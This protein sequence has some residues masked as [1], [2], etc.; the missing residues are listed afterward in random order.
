[1]EEIL[2]GLLEG[3]AQGQRAAPQR[4]AP[5]ADPLTDILGGIL[6][7]SA[8]PQPRRSGGGDPMAE[9]LEGILGG[10]GAPASGGDIDPIMGIL[11]GILGGGAPQARPQQAGA[12][13]LAD[14]LGGILGGGSNRAAN[15]I[16]NM[17]AEKL[18]ISPMI[19]NMIVSFFMAKLLSNKVGHMAPG[20]P[21][22]GMNVRPIRAERQGLD[23]DDLLDVMESGND[24]NA[25]LDETGMTRDLAKY[26]GI[27]KGTASNGLQELLKIFGSKR[28]GPAPVRSG[29]GGLEG[30]LDTWETG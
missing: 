14:I 18:G 20:A 13:G 27:D 24:V 22:E 4:Q 17:L 23:L 11:G 21:R 26:A 19:A 3:A 15:P 5:S 9:M 1:M 6:G 30:L 16:V 25:Q 28:R 2:R 12:G 29:S 10:G 8:A 7:G